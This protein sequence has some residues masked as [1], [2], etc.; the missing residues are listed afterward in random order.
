MLKLVLKGFY[1]SCKG[2]VALKCFTKGSQISSYHAYCSV[3]SGASKAQQKPN[4]WL[5]NLEVIWHFKGLK[6]SQ[7][8]ISIFLWGLHGE[9]EINRVEQKP[10]S[11]LYYE[12]E[13]SI[14]NFRFY[15]WKI[16]SQTWS[17]SL[18]P[19]TS[20]IWPS[21]SFSILQHSTSYRSNFIL[22]CLK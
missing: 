9:M 2:T 8:V 16:L 19:A 17:A 12:T 10:S 7:F 5:C 15:Y 3:L 4:F 22:S 11:N 18:H 13:C 6:D 1:S 14:L 20:F 21:C